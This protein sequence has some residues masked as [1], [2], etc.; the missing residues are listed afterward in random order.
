MRTR[1]WSI[2]PRMLLGLLALVL[3]V[4]VPAAAQTETS[5]G[6]QPETT[7]TEPTETDPA[8]PPSAEETAAARKRI[9]K[10]IRKL[11]R[12][13]W[14]WQ[15]LMRVPRARAHMR[16]ESSVSLDHHRRVLRNWQRKLRVT[17]YRAFHPPRLRAWLCIKRHEG[18]WTANTGNGYYGGL[19]MDLS[20]QR[21]YGRDLLRRKGTA[22]R[23]KPIEQIW[24]AER[25]HR[26]GRGFYPWPNTARYC[27]LI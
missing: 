4:A 25:A 19:Q 11:R 26:S 21:A 22:D 7:D 15:K 16:A 5:P 20:F 2:T 3:A 10:R 24:V 6:E 14:N 12:Q 13:V 1:T 9:L 23:W 18:A 27:G 17:R 8:E